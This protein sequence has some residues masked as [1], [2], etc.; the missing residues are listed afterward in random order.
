MAL[1]EHSLLRYDFSPGLTSPRNAL[2]F[3]LAPVFPA[4]FPLPFLPGNYFENQPVIIAC[5]D[6]TPTWTRGLSLTFLYISGVLV[7]VI[8]Y[9]KGHGRWPLLTPIS[10]Y[11]SGFSERETISSSSL[12]LESGKS[13]GLEWGLGKYLFVH[14][15]LQS[16]EYPAD[17]S[18]LTL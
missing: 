16:L 5:E 18:A 17:I 11:F 9:L 13:P 8:S 10:Q 15:I 2:A 3:T 12:L 14:C 7:P 6:L 4:V 1:R